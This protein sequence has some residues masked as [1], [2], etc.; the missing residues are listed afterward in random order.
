MQ[1]STSS[2][3]HSHQRRRLVILLVAVFLPLLLTAALLVPSDQAVA[4]TVSTVLYRVNTGNGQLS[5]AD[6]STTVWSADTTGSPSPYLAD[7]GSNDSFS[8]S[9]P[10]S[11]T[12]PSIQGGPAPE[13]LFQTERYDTDGATAEMQW[14]FPITGTQLVEVRLYLAE[15]FQTSDGLRVFDVAV[16]GTVPS[17]YN[18]I[19]I[20]ALVGHDAAI[21]LPHTV[22]VSDGTLDVDLLHG[23]ADNPKISGI[24]VVALE[25]EG[26]LAASPSSHDFGSVALDDTVTQTVTLQNAGVTE[27]IHITST[28]ISGD[29]VF[30]APDISLDLSPG[31]TTTLDVSFT[32]TDTISYAADLVVEHD[33]TNSPVTIPFNGEGFDATAPPVSFDVYALQGVSLN[34]PTSLE[35]GPD[36]RLYVSQQNGMIYAYEIT[37]TSTPAYQVVSTEGIDLVQNI[38]NHNDDGTDSSQSN[39]QVTGLVVGGTASNPVLYVSSSD[40]RISVDE[41]SGLD[42]NSGIIT[43]LTWNGSSWDR[44]DIVRGLPRSEENHSTNGL[45]LNATETTLYV[46]QGGHTNKGAPGSN[47]AGTP[48]YFLAGAILSVDLDAI[49]TM[50]IYTDQRTGTQFIYDLQTLDDPDRTNID[51]SNANFPYPSGHPRYDQEVDPG[52]PFGGNNGSNMAVPDP[53]GPVQIHSPGFRNPYDVLYTTFGQLYTYDNGPNGGWGGLPLI[54]DSSGTLEGYQGDGSTTYDPGAGDY[55]T[56]EFNEDGSSGHSDSLHYIDSPD[57]YGGHPAPIRAFPEKA[58]IY[59][60]EEISGSWQETAQYTLTEIL[61]PDL[62]PTDFS[63]NTDECNYDIL[64]KALATVGASTN[65]LA[66]YTAS[67]FGG[68]MQGDLLAASFDGNIYRYQL[69]VAGDGVLT[70][71]ALFSGFGSTPLDVTTQSDGDVFPGTVWAATYGSD[72]I[73][74]F[75]PV[76][77]AT[78]TGDDNPALDE[79]GD[80]YDN[81]DEIDNGTDPCSAA[82]QPPDVD[83]DGTSDL[84]D[85]DDDN[86]GI[87]DGVDAF[88]IDPNNG[89]ATQLPIDYPF[90]NNDPGTGFFGLGFTGLMTNGTDYLDL[91]DP[92]QIAAGGASGKM[93][94]EEVTAGDAYETDNSQ[95]NGF[96]F[97]IDVDTNTRPFIIHTNLE[98]PFFDGQTP[99]NYQS[100]GMFIG[101]GGQANY[102]KVVMNANGG[103]GGVEVLIEETDVAA[104]TQYSNSDWDGD[105]IT[106]ASAVDLYLEVDPQ[107]QTAQPRISV[108]GGATIFDL[109]A[110]VDIPAYWLDPNDDKGMAVGIISTSTGPGD[111]FDATWDFINID[112]VPTDAEAFTGVTLGGGLDASTYSSGS[113]EIT[114]ES[115]SQD[116]LT[117]TIDLSS[118]MLPNMVFDPADGSSAGDTTNKCLVADS[119]PSVT[120]Y[121]TPTDN[122][123]DPFSVPHENGYYV[124]TLNFTDFN[125]GETFTFSVDVDPTSIQGSSA[126]GPGESG[127]V[128]GLELTGSAVN[129]EFSDLASI[130]SDLYRQPLSDGGGQVTV[131]DQLP[132]APA[133][134]VVGLS[135]PVTTND[136][137]QTI[138]IN[139]PAD[140]EVAL[141]VAEA[142]LFEPS[143]GVVDPEPYEGN[144]VVAVNE[145]TTTLDTNGAGTIPV[146][147]TNSDPTTST[148]YGLNYMTAVV[149]ES[150]GD[151]SP[152]SNMEVVEYDP[153]FVP[154]EVL[155]RVNGGGPQTAAADGSSPDWS[156]DQVTANAGGT[157]QTGT[158]SPYVNSGEITPQAYGVTNTINLDGAVPPAA[159][160]ELFQNERWDEPTSPEMQWDFPVTEGTEVEVRLYLTEIFDGI[161]GPGERVFD[162]SVEGTIPTEFNDIDP[163]ALTGGLYN[164]T[165]ISTTT[166]V[167]G[168]DNLDLDFIHVT[169]NPAIKGIEIVQ[170]APPPPPEGPVITIE[171]PADGEVIVGDEITVTWT[172]T[173]TNSGDHVHLTL[174]DN[175]YVGGLPLDGSYVF[176]NVVTGTHVITGQVATTA[177]VVYTNTEATDVFNVTV[178]EPQ[179]AALIE[180][181]PGGGVF[182][183]TYS[184]G[185]F[186]IENTGAVDIV[187]VTL[188]LRTAWMPDVVFDPQGTAGDAAGKCLTADSGS[189]ATGFIAPTDPCSDP[190]SVFHNGTNADDGYDVLTLQFNDFNPGETFSFSTDLDPTSI[191]NATDT[192]DAGAISGFE[193]I[194]ALADVEF[195]GDVALS[196]NLYDEG[197]LGGSAATVTPNEAPAPTIDM[198]GVVVPTTLGDANQTVL[199]TGTPGA[200]FSL[201]QPNARL[202]LDENT[203]GGYDIDPF[204]AN[205][206]LAKS[207]YSGT[208]DGSGN[209]SVPVTLFI[210]PSP[211][212]GPDANLNHFIAVEE[213][214]N[215]DFG[216]TS[217]SFV[218]EYE[219]P[220]CVNAGGAAY[221]ATD[222]RFFTGDTFFTGGSTYSVSDPISNTV[223]DTLFQTERYGDPFTYTIPITDGT[224]I[225]DLMFAELYHG[226]DTPSAD[227]GDRVFSVDLEGSTVLSEYD[228]IAE[229]G[230]PLT[231]ITET[232]TTTVSGGAANI[233]F[234]ASPAGLDENAKVSAICVTPFNEPPMA[235]AGPDQT[236]VETDG[237]GDEVV[238]LDGSGS[239]D[240]DGTIV[241]YMWSD[242]AGQIATGVSPTVTLAIGTHP[243]TLT[244]E[245]DGGKIDTD[246]VTI[247]VQA[248]PTADA[249]PDQTVV[250]TDGSGDEVVTLD[251]SGSSDPDGTIVSYEWSDNGG[252]IATGVSPTVTLDVGTHTITL[253]VTD[254]DS[255]TDTD[256]VTITVQA[257][258]TADAGP[259]QTVVDTDGSGDEVVTLDGSG[260]SD[261][262]GTIV[263][264]EWS[265]SGGQIATGVSPTVTLDV[266]T[267]SITLTVTDGDSLTDTDSVTITVNASDNEAPV[268]DAGPDQTVIDEDGSG[269]EE[270][271]LDGSGS[272]D[273][274]GTIVSYSWSEDGTEIATG[275]QP[276]VTLDVGTHSIVL[277]VTDDDGATD[278]DTVTIT[279]ESVYFLPLVM[280]NSSP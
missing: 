196:S 192:G 55:C 42:T 30:S 29:S 68:K 248:P 79:D 91:Y 251:G 212:A 253:T 204:E 202:Y 77:F 194:G 274:D 197:S 147:L 85:D 142:A 211:D 7:P 54:Y 173:N 161:T 237:S 24:E 104:N 249:G 270:V 113:F 222:G 176:T 93:T 120:G 257:P 180:V 269:D 262:D 261:P 225:V 213:N 234:A 47:F 117:V 149:V 132:A 245:D 168:G 70:E 60:Y 265:D 223:D 231:A 88:A 258:P 238:T 102:L 143:G 92:T 86:D 133:I 21:M 9:D 8:T 2:T 152:T 22:P 239:S 101:D 14:E 99:E 108:D 74:V 25:S 221:T 34:N 103:D 124:V 228:I 268:A 69:N 226:V 193:I 219:P 62:S 184:G 275:E 187:S 169:E 151:T 56:S 96:Q 76:D 71:T 227:I 259:D 115:P 94:V 171:E 16:E 240:P 6:S 84:N 125:P 148:T 13:A 252:Q 236:V 48:E 160:M 10:I 146:T 186:Q 207:L 65:G 61:P 126:P 105:V 118:A 51:N 255:L 98:S 40:P 95:E 156:E 163:Y 140:A 32:P 134:N 66:E 44:V 190:Y 267:H 81:A 107:N 279:V 183:S 87:L 119:D 111:P 46:A 191:K 141:L 154:T 263:S 109:G 210:E 216:L 27:T 260:S 235:D 50:P 37:R 121:V 203:P 224:Y 167:T 159:P 78:C 90:F 170:V 220:V 59:I 247:T 200:N 165:M 266:G 45:D 39:R 5:P 58:G 57:Y 11:M 162:V 110:P 241:S 19:D 164:G 97:G 182:A 139:G 243:I 242:S 17:V 23:A 116:I 136:P 112:Y 205:E 254:S 100:F 153:D 20:H 38:A 137:S 199:I 271:T 53:N 198:Q 3:T 35:L 75:E 233:S 175:P 218:V 31:A 18:D 217:K 189:T 131:T 145:Y 67:N 278:T 177:H 232:F 15:I 155:F 214:A 264:Y 82:S 72:D 63:T 158:P 41:D 144:S 4:Q 106:E 185:A 138:S 130:T 49:E 181:N 33:G 215:G 250:E 208:F 73:T 26:Y 64:S 157:A 114:N 178:Q 83:G 129:V 43:R 246:S 28:T 36:G 135:T 256:S 127:S 52:D 276:T 172:T 188:D 229:T 244:V 206:A 280:R 166:V 201:L 1:T 128:S 174:D 80:G 123:A 150:D 272:D 277:T 89:T 195:A 230:T 273:P 179:P 209:A 12:H 122:C